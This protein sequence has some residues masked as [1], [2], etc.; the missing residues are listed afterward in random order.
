MVRHHWLLRRSMMPVEAAAETLTTP[1][2]PVR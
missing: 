1:K 2:F